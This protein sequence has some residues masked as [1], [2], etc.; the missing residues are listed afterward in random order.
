MKGENLLIITNGGGVGV[1][2]TDAAERY[3]IPLQFAPKDVQEELK[4]HMPEFGSAKNRL[5]SQV[6]LATSGIMIQSNLPSPTNGR[7]V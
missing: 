1:L 2:A 5:T 7:M 3:G 6:W 4:K